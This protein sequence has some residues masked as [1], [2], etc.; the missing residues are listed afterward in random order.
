MHEAACV[1]FLYFANWLAPCV[2]N[3]AAPIIIE[4]KQVYYYVLPG[5]HLTI[6][7][8]IIFLSRSMGTPHV[9]TYMIRKICR[10]ADEN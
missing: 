8:S 2:I 7:S 9:H 3:P 5:R 6:Y 1:E 10:A 4:Q